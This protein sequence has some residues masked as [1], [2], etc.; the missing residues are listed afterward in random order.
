VLYLFK[1]QNTENTQGSVLE[2]KPES[3]LLSP[4][5]MFKYSIRSE[6]TRK[7]YERRLRNFFNFIQFE[8][9]TKDLEVRCDSFAQ[10]GKDNINWVTN[11]IINFLQFQKQRVDTVQITA[12]TLKNF[13]KS[14]KVFCDSADIDI[15]WKKITRGL[16]KGRQSANDRTPTIQEIRKL[17]EYPDRRIKPIV[18]TMI[19]S[20]IR[21][22]S[23]DYLQWKHIEPITNENGEIV[24]AKLSVYAGDAEEYYTFITPEAYKALKEWM[25]FRVSYGEKI[26]GISWVIRDLWQTTNMNY[27]AKW[28]LATNPKRLKSSG[29]KRLLE[30]ALWE[31]G[32][33]QPLIDNARRH[34]WKAAHG[35]RKF[36]KTR[37]E[38]VMKPINV[39]L[40][41]GHDIGISKS[42]YKPTER[43]ILEDYLRAVE[44]LTINHDEL[45]LQKR[46]TELTE[47][48]K[49]D[50][51]IIQGKLSEKE[52][53][54]DILKKHQGERDDALATL[55]DQVMK[56]MA[57]V[58]ELKSV[59]PN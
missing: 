43:E 12:S 25:D 41:M 42:Y 45:I 2:H 46:V 11:Q 51:Y 33:R 5:A 38:Q 39:E 47:R 48:S 29:I 14:L 37:A 26:T 27:G 15:P 49:E 21:L 58:Q 50:N 34:E 20:G 35:L 4:Y 6:L 30:R 18:Y 59:K 24:A 23:W 19:S 28:G 32:I 9:E 17:T 40:T 1:L 22:G 55:S 8:N 53:E 3:Q 56:L 7:Y 54:I 36:Y 13:V 52:T 31:Q 10:M 57:E 44:M 16:P